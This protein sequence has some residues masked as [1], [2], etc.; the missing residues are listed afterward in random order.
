M[1]DALLSIA[2]LVLAA[3]LGPPS[4]G[5]ISAFREKGPAGLDAFLK[6]YGPALDGCRQGGGSACQELL[7]SLDRVAGQ[8]GALHSR[9]FWYTD[10]EAAKSA[11]LASG[12]PILSL[13]LLGRLDEDFSCA[14]SRFFRT[15]LYSDGEISR[16]LRERFVLH[17]KSV[18]PAPRVTVDFGD[19][20]RLQRTLTG[21]SVHYVLA[22]DGRPLDALP[23]LLSPR[24]FLAGLAE[25]EGTALAYARAPEARREATLR[26]VHHRAQERLAAELEAEL[27]A[28]GLRAPAENAVALSPVQRTASADRLAVTKSALEGPL[29]G[30]MAARQGRTPVD[31]GSWRILGLRHLQEARLSDA[32]R[33]LVAREAPDASGAVRR[34]EERIAEDT[35]RNELDLHARLHGWFAAGSA[36]ADL[37]ALNAR[38]YS[39]L[40]LAPDPDDPWAGLAPDDLFVGLPEGGKAIA[41]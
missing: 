39:E 25:A 27:G 12:R 34:L 19:G 11:A 17:W 18:R 20:R 5:A 9:L 6:A 40:F 14:N 1:P 30:S 10:L 7:D 31:G 33:E 22:P 4:P 41:R 32:A 13:H 24:A 16:V 3:A 8:R 21:N 37:E 38:V 29:V 2:S 15:V 36:P 28:L 23:G 26:A 35:A